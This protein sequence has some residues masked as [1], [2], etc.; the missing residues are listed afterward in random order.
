[1][2]MLKIIILIDEKYVMWD[3]LNGHISM[4]NKNDLNFDIYRYIFD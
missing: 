1:M 2:T 4:K 3:N